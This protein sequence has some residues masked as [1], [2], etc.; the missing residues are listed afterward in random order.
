M[1]LA[2]G[3]A[4]PVR[5]AIPVVDSEVAP[6]QQGGAS[7]IAAPD[8]TYQP[9]Q[10][11]VLPAIPIQDDSIYAEQLSAEQAVPDIAAPEP[12]PVLALPS[13]PAAPVQALLRSAQQQVA[14]GD[15]NG[16]AA[17]LE[18]AQRIAPREPQVL[19]RLAEVRLAQGDA[20]EAE[21][22]ARRGLSLS[23]DQPALQAGLWDL[24]ADALEQ[25]GDSQGA[26]Q[27]RSKARVQL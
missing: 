27:A 9:P 17:S 22:L 14:A 8:S 7:A 6:P 2:S 21:Q 12:A 13:R 10:D 18:R 20:S 23:G 4:G 16:A 3:C 26:E 5:E 24:I 25:Q 19:Y 1:L 15:Y 11:R